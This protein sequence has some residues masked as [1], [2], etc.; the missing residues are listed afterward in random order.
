MAVHWP[1]SEGLSRC[2]RDSAGGLRARLLSGAAVMLVFTA[3]GRAPDDDAAKAAFFE[4]RIRPL[5]IA[6]CYECHS[7][8]SGKRKGGLLL[9]SRRGWETGGDSGEAVV[10]GDVEKSLL[11][12]AVRYE[13][14]ALEMPP[15]GRLAEEEVRAL[16]TWVADGAH[17]PRDEP[18]KT[19]EEKA[20]AIDIEAGRRFWAFRP[21]EDRRIP[22]VRRTGWPRTPIDRFILA[23]LEAAGVEP[24][25]DA[26]PE[27]LLRRLHYDLTG[28]PPAPEE[29]DAWEAVTPLR[30][31]ERV[32]RLLASPAFGETWG[33]HWLDVARYADSTG[34]GRTTIVPE[35]W[36]YRNYVIESFGADRS[37]FDFVRE[38]IAGDLLGGKSAPERNAA[39]IATGFL[40]LGPKNLDLQDKELLLMN[41]VDE[42]VDTVG[43]AFL[44]MTLGCARCHD[45][46]FDPVPTADYYALAGIFLSTQTLIR[47]NIST[48]VEQPLAGTEELQEQGRAHAGRLKELAA[49][50][51]EAE[52]GAGSAGAAQGAAEEAAA[53]AAELRAEL[54]EWKERAPP[55]A[56]KAVS[57]REAEHIQDC[58]IRIRGEARSVGERAPRG[59]LQ[60][61]SL[62][63]ESGPEIRGDSSGRK[64]LAEWLTDPRNP[65]TARVYVNRVWHHLL[66]RGIVSS[67]DNF[68]R[69][70]EP[71]THP[72][73]LDWLAARF[74][75]QGCSTKWLVREIVRSRVYGLSSRSKPES[76]ALDPENQWWGRASRRRLRAEELRDSLLAVS[77]RLDRARIEGLLTLEH[78]ETAECR[79]VYLPV[80]RE[81]GSNALLDAFDFPDPSSVTG[82][83]QESNLPAQSLYLLNSPFVLRHARLSAER[84]LA[85]CG[86]WPADSALGEAWRRALSR[87]PS[88]AERD[89]ALAY[90]GAGR[91]TGN[92]ERG[93]APSLSVPLDEWA[94]LFQALFSS[95]DFR[96]LN[97]EPDKE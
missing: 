84:L 15:D 96:Y 76:E 25:E 90:L 54:E 79:T 10:P 73:L 94:G 70:G 88:P 43:Q 65:L 74:V 95:V 50:L 20:N 19:G 87:L 71:P 48:L 72:H 63:G 21:I 22:G 49:A 80:F 5:L 93:F 26:G 27:A 97:R 29:M 38:Q 53:R 68:G 47:A 32:D 66:G 42:Q 36:R 23:R 3:G 46:K 24:A 56:P 40:A 12:Q 41:T 11:L 51:A 30:L 75:E 83:R 2:R 28:L 81:E 14:P 59:F 33:R 39:L 17:D 1:G 69:R 60:A 58:A 89:A 18:A 86:D 78:L 85:D 52:E 13:H 31:E 64:E 37:F 61:A 9:D 45:H 55:P 92:R 6:H 57:V 7:L 91:E 35:A 44:G 34:G 16:E 82:R 67:P 8:E 4:R 62:E 77:G